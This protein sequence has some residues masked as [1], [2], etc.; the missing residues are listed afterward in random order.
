MDLF[1]KDFQQV[2]EEI[3]DNAGTESKQ[4]L[5]NLLHKA[6]ENGMVDF[7]KNQIENGIVS[8][9]ERKSNGLA[10]IH[11]AVSKNQFEVVKMLTE[12]GANLNL[13]AKGFGLQ[14]SPL[15][16]ATYKGN[17]EIATFLL[18]NGA[19]ADVSVNGVTPL[20]FGICNNDLTTIDLL[21]KKTTKVELR[22]DS[23]GFTPIHFAVGFAIPIPNTE[24]RY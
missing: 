8:I 9:N 23:K 11:T 7:L 18:E 3:K 15:H 4:K 24:N 6:V 14:E 17:D 12:K 16:L 22:E 5:Q 2:L 10:L 1:L 13:Q 20:H 19:N 21:L